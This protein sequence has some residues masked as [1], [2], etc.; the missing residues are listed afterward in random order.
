MYV[1]RK[2][3]SD[4]GGIC[5]KGD[6]SNPRNYKSTIEA[7]P[8]LATIQD[9]SIDDDVST[10]ATTFVLECII[11]LQN[12]RI[13]HLPRCSTQFSINLRFP[14]EHR[15]WASARRR[16]LRARPCTNPVPAARNQG[17]IK[18]WGLR[19]LGN[20]AV[21]SLATRI[22]GNAEPIGAGYHRLRRAATGAALAKVVSWVAGGATPVG[23]A[24][25]PMHSAGG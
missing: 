11:F 7:L 22:G 15:D 23:W 1:P 5:M 16:Q 12:S 13:I 10:N 8:M 4:L 2:F 6:G 17:L 3:P 21:R 19:E 9:S 20:L 24:R 14:R 18:R 25:R